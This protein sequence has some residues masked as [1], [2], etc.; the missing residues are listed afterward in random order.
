M[1]L[2]I[3]RF[4][5]RS[6]SAVYFLPV[7]RPFCTGYSLNCYDRLKISIFELILTLISD[8]KKNYLNMPQNAGNDATEGFKF[9]IFLGKRD[10]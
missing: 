9:H 7:I 1:Q 3:I 6:W 10:P 8:L 5:I 4:V 2:W